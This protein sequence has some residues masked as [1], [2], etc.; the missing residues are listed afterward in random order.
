MERLITSIVY[1]CESYGQK[2]DDQEQP[3]VLAFS[4]SAA[5]TLAIGSAAWSRLC[6]SS[7][8]RDPA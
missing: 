2:D 5:L 1:G 6:C 4:G 7:V 8:H 3:G